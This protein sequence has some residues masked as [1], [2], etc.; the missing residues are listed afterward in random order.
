MRVTER[1]DCEWQMQA[2]GYQRVML[3]LQLQWSTAT[4]KKVVKEQVFSF[5][6][7]NEP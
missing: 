1:E 4:R 3:G 2:A 5:Q 6:K 7:T